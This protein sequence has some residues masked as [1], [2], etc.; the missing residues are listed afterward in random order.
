M[1][2]PT[3]AIHYHYREVCQA[4][5]RKRK[6]RKKE[7]ERKKENYV[8]RTFSLVR[9]HTYSIVLTTSKSFICSQV[10]SSSKYDR[11]FNSRYVALCS[12]VSRIY[13]FSS[14]GQA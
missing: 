11:D 9:F 1:S 13:Q 2:C 6:K 8:V 14:S 7:K 5:N 3:Q 4:K 10:C 12:D